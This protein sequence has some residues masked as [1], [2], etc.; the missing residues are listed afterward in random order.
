MKINLLTLDLKSWQNFK[1]YKVWK[2]VA[3]FL[4]LF[5]SIWAIKLQI[6]LSRSK[7]YSSRRSGRVLRYSIQIVLGVTEYFFKIFVGHVFICRATALADLGAT[8]F[9]GFHAVFGKIWQNRMLA[10]PP[11][12]GVNV[13]LGEILDPPLHW[14]PCFELMV[15]SPLGTLIRTLWRHTWYTFTEIHLWCDTFASV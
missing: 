4:T 5:L 10:P 1:I 9:L 3:V 13:P 2:N 7:I 6:N 15:T 8:K 12:P 11:L 14:Y